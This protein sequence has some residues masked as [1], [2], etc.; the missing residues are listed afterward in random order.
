M[1]LKK[2]FAAADIPNELPGGNLANR[3]T[4]VGGIMSAA[5]N[6]VFYVAVGIVLIFLIVGGIKY[7]TSGGD[8]KAAAAA[9][10]TVTHALIGAVI[11]LAFRAILGVILNLLGI[12]ANNY[13]PGF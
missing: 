8:P 3:F 6:I 7:A 13:I 12:T 1:F 2:V 5:V 10:E 11:V 9:K 4:T